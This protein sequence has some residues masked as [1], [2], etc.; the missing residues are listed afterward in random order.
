MSRAKSLLGRFRKASMLA[1]ALT[2]LLL[3]VLDAPGASAQSDLVG[4]ATDSTSALAGGEAPTPGG[5]DTESDGA[6]AEDPDADEVAKATGDEAK[7]AFDELR[8]IALR[9]AP[10]F[11]IVAVLLVLAWLLGRVT[12]FAL[13]R[14][15]GDWPRATAIVALAG[16]SV[17]V[18]TIAVCVTVIAGDVRAFLGS[19]G[20]LG[21]AASWAL[22]TPIESFTGWLLNAFR[23]YYR[24][25]DRVEVGDIFGDVY[26]I[27][28]LTTTVWEIGTPFRPGFVR[29]EQPTGRLITFPNNQVLTGSVTNLTRDF[30]YVWD[31]LVVAVANESDLR[32]TYRVLEQAAAEQL[33]QGMSEAAREYEVILKRAGLPDS[34]PTAP[35]VFVSVEDAWTSFT[36]RYLVHARERRKTKSDL[37]LQLSDVLSQKQHAGRIVPI[38]PRQQLQLIGSD[39]QP[40]NAQWFEPT[41]Q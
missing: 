36:L 17:W 27:D 6:G 29:A 8:K 5:D 24:V 3:Y 26:R 34:V 18:L 1:V 11:T 19:V 4:A 33:G 40:R 14:V 31:E 15:L 22:Q 21:L 2:S 39:G 41:A 10:K 23:G 38:I 13:R 32:H 9:T 28:V 35:Q 25:G 16:V 37:V 12:R 7:R 20:L 30:P